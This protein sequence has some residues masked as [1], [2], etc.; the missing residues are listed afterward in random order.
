L[1]N[2][3]AY[4]GENKAKLTIKGFC[5]HCIFILACFCIGSPG[6]PGG[7]ALAVQIACPIKSSQIS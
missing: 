2:V 5:K 6:G 4:V 3:F 1:A 7:T